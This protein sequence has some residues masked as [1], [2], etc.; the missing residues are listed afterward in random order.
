MTYEPFLRTIFKTKDYPKELC[1]KT[2]YPVFLNQKCLPLFGISISSV[3]SVEVK[4]VTLYKLCLLVWG[5]TYM[6]IF[7]K[8][9]SGLWNKISIFK[10]ERMWRCKKYERENWIKKIISG[11]L[12]YLQAFTNNNDLIK[13][14]GTGTL[15]NGPTVRII[16][17]ST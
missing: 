6:L 17:R 13:E 1:L 3:S 7:T 5:W 11:F 15:D 10:S 16:S 12:N 2:E 9:W 8:N 4:K 14:V